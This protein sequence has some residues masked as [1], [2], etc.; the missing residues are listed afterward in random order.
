LFA[1]LI[2]SMATATRKGWKYLPLLPLV[3]AILHLSYG[4]GFLVGLVKFINRWGDKVGKVPSWSN[5][6]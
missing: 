1:N 4:L 3:F 2:A 6:T 5:E